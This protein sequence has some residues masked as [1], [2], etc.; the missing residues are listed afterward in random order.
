MMTRAEV[1]NRLR[2]H[3][4]AGA[5]LT[6]QQDRCRRRRDLFDLRERRCLTAT[7]SETISRERGEHFD[8]VAR[9]D[10]LVGM[11]P[12]AAVVRRARDRARP[13]CSCGP[14]PG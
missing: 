3:F 7:L 12:D 9:F 11:R 6:E 14:A 2:E 10:V 4:L 1:V 8:L 5:G 13:D